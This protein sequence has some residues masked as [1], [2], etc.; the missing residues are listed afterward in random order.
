MYPF[1]N[2]KKDKKQFGTVLGLV[3][4]AWVLR[5]GV[6]VAT[7]E[8]PEHSITGLKIYYYNKT[9]NEFIESNVHS[10]SSFNGSAMGIEIRFT[11]TSEDG[12]AVRITYDSKRD[13]SSVTAG[14]KIFTLS[15]GQSGNFF[16]EPSEYGGTS[17][18][19]DTVDFVVEVLPPQTGGVPQEG[20][21][22]PTYRFA[23]R[24]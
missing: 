10:G 20:K 12:S 17:M 18:G 5:R 19:V 6:S 8:S 14:T 7:A 15:P 13:G 3:G 21:S 2:T 1:G 11:D 22:Y 24:L 23:Y 16:L 4:L 9:L